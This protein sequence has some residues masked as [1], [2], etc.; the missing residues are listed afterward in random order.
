M[1]IITRMVEAVDRFTLG[2]LETARVS[3]SADSLARA[4]VKWAEDFY[5]APESAEKRR[6]QKA[7]EKAIG[8]AS[9]AADKLTEERETVVRK[10]A[11]L[12]EDSNNEAFGRGLKKA[13]EEAVAETIAQI[14]EAIPYLVVRS[15]IYSFIK[16]NRNLPVDDDVNG[17]NSSWTNL[18]VYLNHNNELTLHGEKWDAETLEAEYEKARRYFNSCRDHAAILDFNYGRTPIL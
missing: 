1:S 17:I 8:I 2:L 3:A 7:A 11:E 14:G 15:D 6:A 16:M 13:A 9:E 4:A 10:I 12:F 5:H 18:Y